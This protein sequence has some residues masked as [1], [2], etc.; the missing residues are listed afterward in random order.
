MKIKIRKV[1]TNLDVYEFDIDEEQD[2]E[3]L[4]K[5]GFLASMPTKCTECG[6]NDVHLASNK[7][8][9]EKGTFTFVYMQCKCGAKAQLGQYKT[10]GMFWKKFE[11]YNP[12]GK[13]NG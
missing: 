3:A 8:S 5:A 2:L 13:I 9:S 11:V 6:E 7:S 12:D 10:G 1:L 4:A